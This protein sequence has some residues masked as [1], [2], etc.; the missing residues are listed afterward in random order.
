V[1]GEGDAIAGEPV[2]VSVPAGS[3]GNVSPSA[4]YS[5]GDHY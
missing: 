4:L 1:F 3:W 2:A 5:V